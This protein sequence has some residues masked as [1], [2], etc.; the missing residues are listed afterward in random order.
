MKVK[1]IMPLSRSRVAALTPELV[2]R[3][4]ECITI[5]L[6]NVGDSTVKSVDLL[7]TI[8]LSAGNA[9]HGT[10]DL[11]SVLLRLRTRASST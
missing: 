1:P 7:A 6:K 11:S 10:M 8:H 9:C 3:S 4:V 5:A 2:V